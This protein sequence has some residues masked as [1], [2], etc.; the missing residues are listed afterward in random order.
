MGTY[1][2]S[3]AF[4]ETGK[5]ISV[6]PGKDQDDN[7]LPVQD[8]TLFTLLDGTRSAIDI[9]DSVMICNNIR[10]ETLDRPVWMEDPGSCGFGM[11]SP[12]IVD[13]G[14]GRHEFE[15][16]GPQTLMEYCMES[17]GIVDEFYNGYNST[18]KFFSIA[19]FLAYDWSQLIHDAEEGAMYKA[20]DLIGEE[21]FE[22]LQKYI[23]AGA[24]H[25]AYTYW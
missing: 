20:R 21:T 2:S 18:M 12:K 13:A 14:S 9:P 25:I 19:D 1:M 4:S 24:T 22:R 16:Y 11:Y 5:R 23:D 10:I 6:Y 3:W 8:Y 17:G 7:P 15:V